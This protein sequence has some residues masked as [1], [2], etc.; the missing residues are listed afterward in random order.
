M[1]NTG[2]KG[3]KRLFELIKIYIHKR[4]EEE[5]CCTRCEEEER[6]KEEEKKEEERREKE[7]ARNNAY[8]NVYEGK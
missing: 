1:P 6:K 7:K 4:I 2:I 8:R 5:A 3:K